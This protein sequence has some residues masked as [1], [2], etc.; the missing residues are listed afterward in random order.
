MSDAQEPTARYD[1]FLSHNSKD[2]PA[3][4][5]IAVKLRQAGIEPWLD[6]WHLT[7]GGRWQEE[8]A[9]A[10]LEKTATC[11]V[12]IGPHGIGNWSREELEL[13]KDRSA[14]DRAYRL[15][16][17]LLPGL[18]EPFDPTDLPPVLSSHTWVDLRA[19]DED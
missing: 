12:F 2:K 1:V 7:P 15:F 16:L 11:A 5:R 6:S 9:E 17:V 14:K 8:I 3:V 13:A 19:G 4:E 18:P 10:V